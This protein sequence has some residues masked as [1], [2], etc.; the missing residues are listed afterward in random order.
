MR[1]SNGA[2][3]TLVQNARVL[4]IS[5]QQAHARAEKIK[6]APALTFQQASQIYELRQILE[7]EAAALA[8][9]RASKSGAARMRDILHKLEQASCS[10]EFAS[11]AKIAMD[12][13]REVLKLSGNAVIEEIVHG[14]LVRIAPL[15]ARSLFPVG[16]ASLSLNEMASIVAAIEAGDSDAARSAVRHHVQQSKV[17]AQGAIEAEN[18]LVMRSEELQQYSL[19][20]IVWRRRCTRD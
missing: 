2:L 16:R 17:A 5:R 12:F 15:Q 14:L 20:P 3:E 8:A 7:G 6:R 4:S 18:E 13:Y 10:N 1:E 19:A 9:E 11:Q